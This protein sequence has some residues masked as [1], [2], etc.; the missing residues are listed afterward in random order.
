MTKKYHSQGAIGFKGLTKKE[1]VCVNPFVLT[2]AGLI[3]PNTVN[4]G[5]FYE[6]ILFCLPIE[7]TVPIYQEWHV[8]LLKNEKQNTAII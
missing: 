3:W 1:I 4:L 2:L 5:H 8:A 6:N 7:H